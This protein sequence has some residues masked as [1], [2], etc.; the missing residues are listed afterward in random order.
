LA[1]VGDKAGIAM[2]VSL[3]H[4]SDLHRDPDNP[5]RNDV[6]LDSLENDRRHY[7]DEENPGIRSPDL[8]IV[9][10]DIIHGVKPDASGPETKLRE[11]YQEA[12]DFLNRLTDRFVTGD[13][14]RVVVIP[15]NHDVSSYHFEKSLRRINILPDRKREL[16][17]QLFSRDSLLRWSWSGFELYEIVDPAMYAQRLGAFAEFYTAFYNGSRTYDLDP[18]KQFDIFDFPMFDL[19]IAGFSSCYNNDLYNRQGAIHPAC[20]AE[21]GSRF[22]NPSLKSR[23]R[24]AVWHHNAEGPP[25]QSDYMDPDLIQNLIDRGVSLGFHGHQ[26]R[27]QFLDTRFRHGVDRRITVVSAGTLCGGAS[28]RF[29]RAYNV[30]ELDTEKRVGRLHLREM[31]NDNLTLPIWGQRALPPNTDGYF[32]FQYDP[33]PQPIVRPNDNTLAL[34]EAQKFHEMAD[35]RNAAEILSRVASVDDLAR[36]LLLDC[37]VKLN[38]MCAIIA[39]FDPPA[40]DAEAIHVM[41]ALWAAGA[42]DRLREMLKLP[43]IAE[44]GDPSVIEMRTKVSARLANER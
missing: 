26:H 33:P 34:I 14:S 20:I 35:Y 12:L 8:I 39:Q 13:R 15:G 28:F 19:T 17:T 27:P 37:Y 5:I 32:D 2:K 16:V 7:C 9:S 18:S 41:D 22:R 11:Q 1:A 36:P 3:L 10:G 30:V 29:G 31:Q 42:R 4:I 44:S 38:D 21:V 40:S 43:L 6:L 25:M 23:L 24:I